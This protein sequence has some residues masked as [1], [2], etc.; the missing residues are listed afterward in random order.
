MIRLFAAIAIPADTA[1]GLARHQQGLPG[2]QWRPA[3]SLH[4]TLGFFGSVV[5]NRADDLASELSCISPA[6]MP[7]VIAGVG[8]F[9][10]GV[11]INAIWA[12]VEE[13]EAL[14]RLATRC[15]TAARRAGLKPETR[16]WRPHVT[17]AYFNRP[18][19]QRVAAW[20]QSHNLLHSPPFLV[21]RFGLYS[22]WRTDDGSSYRL[23][24]CYSLG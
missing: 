10:D 20:I 24:R 7:V 11:E 5:E 18:E 13:N 4:I 6:A 12:G 19:P 22:S 21:D 23:E 3:Q 17:L 9:G 14:R 2:A 16:V 15:E 1:E 8:S